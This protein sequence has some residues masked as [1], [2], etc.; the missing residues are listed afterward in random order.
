MNTR[1]AYNLWNPTK[2]ITKSPWVGKEAQTF[3]NLGR[4]DH[5]IPFVIEGSP[6]SN[7][8]AIECYPEALLNLT[9]S[10]ELLAANINEMG[11]DA[12]VIKVVARMFGLKF[13]TLWRRYEREQRRKRWL[14][15]AGSILL[16]FLSMAIGAYIARMNIQLDKANA[17]LTAVNKEVRAERDRANSERDRAEKATDSLIIVNK[18]VLAERDR[19]N[20]E[21]DRAEKATNSLRTAYDSITRQ[22]AF[23]QQQ[24]AQLAEERDNVLRA[25]WK[26][27]ENRARFVATKGLELIDDHDSYTAML[28]ALELLPESLEH[29]NKPYV[30]EA[31]RL[32]RDAMRYEEVVLKVS[33]GDVNS[34]SFS[35]NGKYILSDSYSLYCGVLYVWDAATG[36]RVC[37]P[38]HLQGD[39][40]WSSFSPTG[41]HIVSGF[42]NRCIQIWDFPSL[43]DLIDETRKRFKDQQL[44]PEERRKYYLD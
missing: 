19:A 29:P 24:N 4:A 18:E 23:I 37:S 8:P 41:Q 26:M 27:M 15:V 36:E 43:Q 30:V 33:A 28:L 14:I 44:T 21:R 10:K 11:R 6:F 12:A 1:G 40:N 39:I 16:A 13:D 32:S 35:P 25:N 3:I 31:E 38:L 5:I 34:V 22:N 20:S 9:G 7:E 42:N 2:N 17:N